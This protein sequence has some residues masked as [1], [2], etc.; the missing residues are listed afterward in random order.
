MN[1]WNQEPWISIE[2]VLHDLEAGVMSVDEARKEIR[3][4]VNSGAEEKCKSS[5]YCSHNTN[6]RDLDKPCSIELKPLPAS[7]EKEFDE[8][9]ANKWRPGHRHD[10]TCE[11]ICSLREQIKTFIS[12]QRKEAER[13]KET[14]TKEKL[15]DWWLKNFGHYAVAMFPRGGTVTN[16]VASLFPEEPATGDITGDNQ[17]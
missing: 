13:A 7:W 3:K 11:F 4:H 2:G 1:D 14:E 5:P 12:S 8:L 17:K 10:E 16:P 9:Y 15:Y 6:G